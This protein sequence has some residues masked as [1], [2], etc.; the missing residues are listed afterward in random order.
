MDLTGQRFSRLLIVK[1]TGY[2]TKSKEIKWECLCDCGNTHISST[3]NIRSGSVR[4]C[5]CLAKELSSERAKILFTKEKKVCLVKDCQDNTQKGGWGFCGKHYMRVKR[6]GDPTYTTPEEERVMKQRYS[7]ME[8]KPAK[9]NTYR[10]FYGRHE[11]R[12]IGEE[13][14]GRKLKTSEHVH[15]KNENK[16][17]NSKDNL[18][19]MSAADHARHH[20]KKTKDV[21]TGGDR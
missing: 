2:R 15:H 14:V 18:E 12:V 21:P 9:E 5:G 16:H 10:K 8:S 4:S 3:G 17:D 20:F 7:L 11:H 13:I 6:Y 19:V 1:D